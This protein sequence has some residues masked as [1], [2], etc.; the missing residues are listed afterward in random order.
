MATHIIKKIWDKLYLEPNLKIV[1]NLFLLTDI[2]IAPNSLEDYLVSIKDHPTP[3]F[4]KCMIISIEEDDLEAEIDEE[5]DE[6]EEII[7]NEDLTPEK[8][9]FIVE[10]ALK[11]DKITDDDS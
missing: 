9:R 8:I 11:L 4:T 1:K 2:N 10:Q 5:D 6:E 3:D 7:E